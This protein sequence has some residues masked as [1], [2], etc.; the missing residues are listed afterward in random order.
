MSQPW[1]QNF[2]PLGNPWLSALAAAIPVCTLFFFLAVRRAP[3]WRAAVYAFVAA[4]AVA[5]GVFHMPALMVAGAVADGLVFGWFRIAWIVV[6]AVFVYDISVDSGQFEIVK[7]SIGDISDDR[8]L[9]VLLI[10]FAFGAL[11]E[12]AGGGGAPVAVSGAMMIGLGFPPFQTAL[13]CLIANSAPVAYGG[14]G[15]PVRTLVAVTGLSEADFSAMIGRILP[16]TTLVLPFWLIRVFCNRRQTL[17]VWPGLLACGISF[18][19]IQFF[20]SN[21]VNASLVDIIGGIGTLLL[22]AIFFK[23]VW[24]PKTSWR[25]EGEGAA[26]KKQKHEQLTAGRILLAWSPFLLLAAFVVVWGLPSVSA[27]LDKVSYKQP[28]PGLHMMVVRTPPVVAKAYAEPALFDVSWLS[29]AGTGTFIAGLIAGPLAGLSLRR[30]IRVFFGS[31]GRLKWSLVAI[32]AMLGVGYITRY[33]GMDATMGMAMAHT[34]VLFPF[35]GTMIGW[36]GVSLSGTDAGSNALFGSLQVITANKLGLSPILM[37]AANSAGGVMGKMVAAQSLVIGC[38][39][40][41]QEGQ[42][43]AL[44]RAV[45]KHSLALMALVGLIV[46]MYAYVFPGAIPQGHQFLKFGR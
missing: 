34:G 21:Y 5:L 32:M 43:G 20:W 19:G 18:G 3:A 11:L 27:V 45:L 4:V 38:A 7:Q 35:F 10:A 22:L 12:G 8:R 40:T 41:G 44:F 42:E 46:L 13:L 30:T 23:Y 16:L 24:S 17:E 2:D 9:Q 25:Y 36:L 14:L 1:L 28:V 15:N 29:T 26:V 6:A 33:C 39:V 31:L 37:G